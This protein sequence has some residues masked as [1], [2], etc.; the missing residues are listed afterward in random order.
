MVLNQYFCDT[1][2]RCTVIWSSLLCFVYLFIK[3]NFVSVICSLSNVNVI[4]HCMWYPEWRSWVS[5]CC[6]EWR[7]RDRLGWWEPATHG[8]RMSS[9]YIHSCV[10]FPVLKI[11]AVGGICPPLWRLIWWIHSVVPLQLYAVLP[12]SIFSSF[13]YN[14]L[15]IF[16]ISVSVY[17]NVLF[18]W[19]MANIHICCSKAVN[20]QQPWYLV[21][22][23]VCNFVICLCPVKISGK[24]LMGIISHINP[25]SISNKNAFQPI[26]ELIREKLIPAAFTLSCNTLISWN[27]FLIYLLFC[28][29]T[30]VVFSLFLCILVPFT[31]FLCGIAVIA[32]C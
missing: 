12:S 26:E 5:H 28:L 19:H 11:A 24:N 17:V 13:T 3:F 7:W 15:T 8:W 16:F 14:L 30:P 22:S 18:L 21:Y 25:N 29:Y 6:A 31:V 4:R 1:C 9:R 20:H 32:S 10:H 2:T 27:F 23:I